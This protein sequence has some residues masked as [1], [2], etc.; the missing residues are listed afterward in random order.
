MMRELRKQAGITSP[1]TAHKFRHDVG[2]E[3]TKKYGI[4]LA[5][6]W[7]HHSSINTTQVYVDLEEEEI[8]DAAK[9]MF[10]D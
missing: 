8:M 4:H 1:L 3:V 9:K 2:T 7:L 5:Q 6:R 10:G